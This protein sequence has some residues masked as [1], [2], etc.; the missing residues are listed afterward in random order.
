MSTVSVILVTLPSVTSLEIS[1]RGSVVQ[2]GPAE[3]PWGDQMVTGL[4]STL[5]YLGKPS[6]TPVVPR[7]KATV[8]EVAWEAPPTPVLPLNLKLSRPQKFPPLKVQH[9]RT[10]GPGSAALWE[11][12][13]Q[14]SCRF[15]APISCL[16]YFFFF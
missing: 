14:P 10:R 5:I 7:I 6:V 16:A 8:F 9:Q 3:W 1:T 2:T 15:L 12:D 13:Q 4:K 11:P